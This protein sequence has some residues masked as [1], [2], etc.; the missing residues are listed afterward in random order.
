[1]ASGS[2]D[3]LDDTASPNNATAARVS[4]T[5][6]RADREKADLAKAKQAAIDKFYASKLKTPKTP[7]QKL[8]ANSTR[9]SPLSSPAIDM[10]AGYKNIPKVTSLF[11]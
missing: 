10:S 5:P 9:P 11:I 3:V 8:Q 7:K 6:T 2:F 1:M 4:M